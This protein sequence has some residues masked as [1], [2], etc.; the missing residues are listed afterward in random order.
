MQGAAVLGAHVEGPFI[1]VKKNGAH[2]VK[3]IQEKCL[4]TEKEIENFFGSIDN[5]SIITIAPELEN[6]KDMIRILTHNN[7]ICSLGHSVSD[8][9]QA[10]EGVNAGANFITHL[11][12]AMMPFHH[13]DPGIIGVLSSNRLH[14]HC[15]YGII[16]DGLH[17][18]PAA[19]RIA[20]RTHPQG[21][22][23]VTDAMAA[24]G[25]GEGDH[26]IGTQNVSVS[27]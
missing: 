17:T 2:P 24:M 15:Y 11:F 5:I 20:H 18:H 4:T 16:A 13:R 8:I 12:N 27:W 3:Y 25:L 6:A 21:A 14:H 26:C 22:I 1:S 9:T 23:L 10:E 19:L 7:V